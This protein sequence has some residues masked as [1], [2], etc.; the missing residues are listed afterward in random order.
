MQKLAKRRLEKDKKN[1]KSRRAMRSDNYALGATIRFFRENHYRWEEIPTLWYS[2]HSKPKVWFYASG[3]YRD[4]YKLEF[5]NAMAFH[6]KNHEDDFE[7][8]SLADKVGQEIDVAAMIIDMR[9]NKEGGGQSLLIMPMSVGFRNV[10]HIWVNIPEDAWKDKDFCFNQFDEIGFKATVYEYTTNGITRY[11]V[12]WQSIEDL[13]YAGIA[14]FETP[15]QAKDW[16]NGGQDTH[17]Y[18]LDRGKTLAEN[19]Y[20]LGYVDQIG[21]VII[22]PRSTRMG[23]N[24]IIAHINTLGV[25]VVPII[26]NDNVLGLGWSDDDD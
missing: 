22:T 18:I 9:P 16:Q 20:L 17:T 8:S 19:P 4:M 12:K 14:M 25:G 7:R 10:Q 1:S 11:G 3:I 26:D 21:K 6:A 13:Y 15:K 5:A 2:K 24:D 23:R